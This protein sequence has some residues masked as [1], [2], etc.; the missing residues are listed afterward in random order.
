MN[1][2][3]FSAAVDEVLAEL[4]DWVVERVDN[5]VVV[6]EDW[7]TPEQDPTGEGILGVYEGVSLAER[8]FD[9][10]GVSPDQIVIFYQPHL[11]LGLA[12]DELRAEIRITV[13][14]EMAH[15]L[16]IDDD[17]LHELGWD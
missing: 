2:R 1:R 14:H 8:G 6:V 13:L 5:L 4:P 9:Y 16:G 3:E 7:P 10:F 11:R 15:H 12:D 17:R